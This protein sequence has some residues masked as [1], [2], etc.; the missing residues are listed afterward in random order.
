MPAYRDAAAM[1]AVALRLDTSPYKFY[2]IKYYLIANERSMGATRRNGIVGGPVCF[3]AG[4]CLAFGGVVD[5]DRRLERRHTHCS[6][7]QRSRP[8]LVQVLT[9]TASIG[10]RQ[11]DGAGGKR[12]PRARTTAHARFF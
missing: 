5:L 2:I 6:G 3:A 1:R 8:S 7:M 9:R 12:A 11:G 4:A 10:V